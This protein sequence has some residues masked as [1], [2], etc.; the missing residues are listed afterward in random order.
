MD[1]VKCFV[2]A[3]SKEESSRKNDKHSRASYH[4]VNVFNQ[5]KLREIL[6]PRPLNNYQLSYD[7]RRDK[8]RRRQQILDTYSD[9]HNDSVSH[10]TSYKRVACY[11]M[12]EIKSLIRI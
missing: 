12:K 8:G 2:L 11:P 1:D 10:C 3:L 4:A 9:D 6:D 5:E 7:G